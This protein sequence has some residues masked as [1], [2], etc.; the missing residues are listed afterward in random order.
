MGQHTHKYFLFYFAKQFVNYAK[1]D[2]PNKK[3]HKPPI[4]CM[5]IDHTSD[6]EL[7]AQIKVDD[8][9]AFEVLFD[10]YWSAVYTTA[11]TYLKDQEAC[12]ELVHDIFLN[13]WGNRH[14]LEISSFKNYLTMASRYQVYKLVRKA[15][16][17]P[18]LFVEEYET[19][20]NSGFAMNLGEEKVKYQELESTIEEALKKLPKKCQEI[21]I[22]SRF[23][24]LSNQEIADKLGISK[25]TVENQITTALKGLRVSI[26][27]V[28]LYSILFFNI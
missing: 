13:I 14:H 25:R 4:P 12:T 19:V 20:P 16:K 15:K 11:F 18:V 17:S 8:N 7:W 10:R 2:N 1:F 9:K 21:F 27:V 24:N 3:T 26:K 22:L 6:A 5:T 23:D 28:A